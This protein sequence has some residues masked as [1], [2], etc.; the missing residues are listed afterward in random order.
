MRQDPQRPHTQWSVPAKFQ[1]NLSIFVSVW[2]YSQFNSFYGEFLPT[3][4]S[5]LGD[6]AP[7]MRLQLAFL[8]ASA[9]ASHLTV[10]RLLRIRGGGAA[11]APV[12]PLRAAHADEAAPAVLQ[13]PVVRP[14]EDGSLI[15]LPAEEFER[16]GLTP[17]GQ[18]R[19]RKLK[20]AALWSSRPDQ[21]I[22][23]AVADPELQAGVRLTAPDMKAL[24]LRV[25][26]DVLVAP[27][28]M[29]LA[30]ERASPE[31]GSQSDADQLAVE[32]Y[33]QQRRRHGWMRAAMWMM[34]GRPH[35]GYGYSYG[36]YGHGRRYGGRTA[37]R[38]RPAYGRGRRV[39]GRM[40][41]RRR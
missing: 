19:V 26:E 36:G 4:A 10:P 28:P 25:G 12:R 39:G 27:M 21:A 6:R 11:A 24:E 16:L 17:G 37:Y 3:V 29:P 8:V 18:V 20:K 22:G 34:Y 7:E 13:L 32:R 2:V 30:A 41:S 38:R 14:T 15:A 23:E 33:R 35:Y 1:Q 31:R 9:S 40:G 5:R